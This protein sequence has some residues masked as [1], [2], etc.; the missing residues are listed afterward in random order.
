M[1][2]I[3]LGNEAFARGAYEAGVRVVASYPGT[4]S[5]EVTENAAKYDEMYVE[6]APN[7]KVA[8][9][10]AVGASVGGARALSCMK[11]VGLNVA[12]DPLFTVSYTGFTPEVHTCPCWNPRIAKRPRSSWLLPMT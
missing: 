2:K 8:L 3:L 11:H 6:W 5:T 7:E 9:E 1:K 10:V 12:A 4:P